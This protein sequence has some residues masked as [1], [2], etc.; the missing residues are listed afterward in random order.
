MRDGFTVKELADILGVHP[1]SVAGTIDPAL[2]KVAKLL[3]ADWVRAMQSIE[4]FI[5]ELRDEREREHCRRLA[6]ANEGRADKSDFNGRGADAQALRGADRARDL[7]A[8]EGHHS[9]T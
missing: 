1:N 9:S 3:E 4:P 5:L 8:T 7:R 6:R 2:R